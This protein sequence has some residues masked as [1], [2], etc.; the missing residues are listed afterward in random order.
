MPYG[1]VSPKFSQ[2]N[3][4][5]SPDFRQAPRID[6]QIG[7]FGGAARLEELRE[8]FLN[9]CIP[10]CGHSSRLSGQ[11]EWRKKS[12]LNERGQFSTTNLMHVIHN[13]TEDKVAVQTVPIY[14][15]M[16]SQRIQRSMTSEQIGNIGWL[17]ASTCLPIC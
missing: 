10:A 13:P 3:A 17:E 15:V 6:Q 12:P 9:T 16:N 11:I 7:S 5:T 8:C 14:T 2:T 4:I 1:F